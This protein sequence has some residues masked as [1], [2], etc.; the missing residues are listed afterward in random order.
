MISAPGHNDP[1]ST[2]SHLL[3]VLVFIGYGFG[4]I[5]QARMSRARV[6]A[7]G[8][9]VFSVLFLLSMSCA[10]HALETGSGERDIM[11][12]LD[13]AGIFVLIAG[14]FTPIHVI[15]GHGFWRWGFLGFVWLLAITGLILKTIYF[16]DLSESLGLALYIA[17]GWLGVVPGYLTYRL[18]GFTFVRPLLFGALAYTAGAMMDFLRWPVL[19]PGVIEAHEMFHIAIIAGIAWHGVFIKRL[20]KL[21]LK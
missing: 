12:R 6:V 1:F 17:F 20:L 14:T 3:A 9:Y 10:Y 13:H 15:A 19:I 5:R 21:P 18:Y 4:L 11:Q 2:L 16:N 7:V 8:V